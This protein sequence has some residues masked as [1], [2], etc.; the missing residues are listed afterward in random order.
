M[1]LRWLSMLSRGQR[2][3]PTIIFT[4]TLAMGE[5]A[6]GLLDMRNPRAAH[7]HTADRLLQGG[8]A[9]RSGWHGA[10]RPHASA[11]VGSEQGGP[12][13]AEC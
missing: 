7:S 10:A 6:C 11:H 13:W 12:N 8:H 4:S 2:L 9:V 3:A 1:M 5:V